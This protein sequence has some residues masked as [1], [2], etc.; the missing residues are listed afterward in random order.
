[1]KHRRSV[2]PFQYRIREGAIQAPSRLLPVMV[3]CQSMPA[4]A[5]DDSNT[6]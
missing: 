3:G 4:K 2:S 6:A 1:M 5:S